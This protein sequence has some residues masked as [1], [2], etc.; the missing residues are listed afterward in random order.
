MAQGG[1]YNDIALN[2]TGRPAAGASIRPCSKTS[3]G[4]PCSPVQHVYSDAALSI[5]KDS[6]S[7]IT[8]DANGNYWFYGTP[9]PM[10][11]QITANGSTY[12]ETINVPIDA[13]SAVISKLNSI[14][15]VDGTRFALTNA[16]I[17]A[18][19]TDIGLNAGTVIIPANVAGTDY[20][21]IA[22]AAGQTQ[23]LLI[24]F[25]QKS[26]VTGLFTLAGHDA[27]PA[28]TTV[29][30]FL[31][32]I[33]DSGGNGH[34]AW[35]FSHEIHASAGHDLSLWAGTLLGDLHFGVPD[36]GN[37]FFD[38]IG[39]GTSTFRCG[40]D[41]PGCIWEANPLG[42][43]TNGFFSIINNN[44][45]GIESFRVTTLGQITKVVNLQVGAGSAS[46]P[47]ITRSTDTGTGF[48]FLSAG[49]MEFVSS[50]S[51]V[52]SFLYAD[53]VT[54]G[55]S[56]AMYGFSSNVDATAASSDVNTSRAAAGIVQ[57]GTGETKNRN[58]F[59]ISGNTIRLT[60]DLTLAANTSLQAIFSWTFPA[61]AINYNFHCSLDYS[62]ATAAASNAF[63]IQAATNAPTNIR[64]SGIVYT[65]A[66]VS[67][68]GTLSTLSSTTATN[69]LTFTP[70]ATGT[71]FTAVLEGQLE[72]GAS[73]NTVNI[74]ASQ[75]NAA[76][77]LTIK[78]GSYCQLF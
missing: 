25:R 10:K 2:S 6:N 67:T 50:T 38:H 30:V 28:T 73:A 8:A 26:V 51:H 66:G 12:T 20:S 52:P 69:I 60:S 70:S 32:L 64:A 74:M 77:L 18:A 17:Q 45:D 57:V 68:S 21:G 33:G 40:G 31:G 16:G 62:Q 72:L 15:I 55:N 27:N 44:A 13:T 7:A 49:N 59:I 24:D 41:T 78:R 58:G 11:L 29:T 46:A 75:S 47:S 54:R 35:E 63:G 65:A 37:F 42:T 5:Q 76:D 43:G 23:V 36:G 34:F 4:T 14:R 71:V 3:T 19:I 56:A 61:T 9:G 39:A 22:F 48:Y 53:N 1:I